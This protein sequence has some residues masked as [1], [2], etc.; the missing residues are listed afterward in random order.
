MMGVNIDKEPLHTPLLG[1]GKGGLD[2]NVAMTILMNSE[3]MD[4]VEYQ[5]Y[6]APMSSEGHDPR[7]SFDGSWIVYG[8]EGIVRQHLEPPMIAVP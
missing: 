4:K 2:P 3:K 7:E 1:A 5:L 6:K 8:R